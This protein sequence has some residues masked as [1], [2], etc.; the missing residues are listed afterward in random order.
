MLYYINVTGRELIKLLKADSWE[1]DRIKGS[2]H[3]MKKG[4]KT[5]SV[6]VH[7]TKDIPKGTLNAIMKEAGLR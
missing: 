2:H 6:P 7:G 3:I 4:K 5:I 1:L